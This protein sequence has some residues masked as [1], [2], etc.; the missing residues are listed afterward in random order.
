VG[1]L[2]QTSSRLAACAASAPR[3]TARSTWPT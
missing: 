3:P 1:G 2:L